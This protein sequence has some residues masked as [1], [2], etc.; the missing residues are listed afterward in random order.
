MLAQNFKTAESLGLL[1]A[2]FEALIK[3]L[4]MLE[5]EEIPY[6]APG[7][8]MRNIDFGYGRP[9]GFNMYH[10]A[11][12]TDCGTV[13]CICGWAEFVGRLEPKSLVM[14]RFR[15]PGLEELFDP[16]AV[17][18]LPRGHHIKDINP[19]QAAIALRNYL[20]F[21]EARWADALAE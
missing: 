1:D 19:S 9:S 17:R 5:R 3:V 12:D 16:P 2:E 11:S 13:C 20:T 18:D 7:D 8:H 6:S 14:K 21:G 15:T 10:F 4:G